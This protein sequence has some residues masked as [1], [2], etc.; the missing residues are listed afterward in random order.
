MEWGRKA[1]DTWDRLEGLSRQTE[2]VL[3]KEVPVV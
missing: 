1:S 3:R 2:T